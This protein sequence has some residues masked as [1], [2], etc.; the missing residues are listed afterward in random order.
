MGSNA[1]QLIPFDQL[2]PMTEAVYTGS[3]GDLPE[4]WNL[5]T[6]GT[7]EEVAVIKRMASELGTLDDATRK[8]RAH[9]ASLTGCDSG[10]PATIDE[11]LDAIGRGE[12]REPALRNGCDHPGFCVAVKT[13]QPRQIEC[14]GAERCCNTT[15]YHG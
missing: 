5:P 14:M 13:S 1:R 7:D 2:A 10:V 15:R 6:W 8:I 9:I 3:A 11:L 12:L 4:R